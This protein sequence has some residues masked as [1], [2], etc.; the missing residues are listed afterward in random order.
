MFFKLKKSDYEK[1]RAIFSPMDDHLAVEAMLDGSAPGSIYVDDPETPASAL[2]CGRR[3]FYLAGNGQNKA[4]I[5]ELRTLFLDRIFTQARLDG[6]TAFVVYY[7]NGGWEAAVEE[8]LEGRNP[9]KVERQYYELT[10]LSN[11]QQRNSSAPLALR[12]VDASLLND[13][14]LKNLEALK[15]ETVSECPSVEEFLRTRLGVC[16][17]VGDEIAGWCLSEYRRGDRCEIGIETL[18]KYQRQG[19]ATLTARALIELAWANGIRRFGWDCY[20]GN[21]PSVATALKLGFEKKSDYSAYFTWVE[22]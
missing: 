19:I 10:T 6:V 5:Q 2:A 20:R 15:A 17:I 7:S 3:R 21:A 13:L 14:K 18:E 9:V 4:F 8:I 22:K 12:R 1:A 16:A 11:V